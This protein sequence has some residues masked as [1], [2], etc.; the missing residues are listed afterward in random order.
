MAVAAYSSKFK[1]NE[2]VD[3]MFF[4]GS[5]R[6]YGLSLP[7]GIYTLL[8]YADKDNNQLFH[9]SEII[10]QREVTLN[11]IISPEKVISHVDIEL[12]DTM[13]IVWAKN[14]PQPKMVAQK[15]SIFY[16]TGT[17][18]TLD[19]P[20]FDEKIATL[21]MYDPASF[22]EYAPTMFYTLEEDLGYKIPII[23]VHGIGGSSRA[24]K[25]IIEHIDRERYKPWFFYYPSGGNLSQFAEFF[26]KL[27]LSGT[28]FSHGKMPTIVIAHSMGGLIV[29]EAINQY[30]G[31]ANE[32]KI[33]LFVS[34]ASPFGGHPG[35]A[36]GE[37]NGPLV[38]PAWRDLSPNNAFI[39]ELYRKPLPSF[40]NHQL[41]YAY[42]NPDK[43][44][45]GNNSDGVVPL[46]SQL[47]PQ[48]QRQAHNQFGFNS[49]HVSILESE[50]MIKLLIDNVNEV[51]GSFPESQMNVLLK[52]GFD[53]PLSDTY[54]PATQHL[55]RT[56][57]KFL[58]ALANGGLSPNNPSQTHF[59][60][61]MQG[62]ISVTTELES[63]FL[64]F[65][66][67]YPDII[68]STH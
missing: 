45:V 64:L 9:P 62:Q 2:H 22:M 43:L 56:S 63:E 23:F 36:A 49:G 3:T 53:V 44:K 4:T 11:T 24:F 21:G 15:P 5:G 35:A 48:V 38:L 68:N 10:G 16:P 13:S 29:R 39:K 59:V 26:Y 37:K 51:K 33:Q 6:H 40:L 27:F 25:T 30:E 31:N 46:F 32:N 1:Q 7:E 14:I 12:T 18:R 42:N 66:K 28:V 55:I 19:D 58:V 67:E 52:G 17:I 54:S 47:H 8:V 57:G 60:Q 20:I 61:A 50:E 65:I 41:F 34:I